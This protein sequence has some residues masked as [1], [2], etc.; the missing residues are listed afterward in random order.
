MS[1][2]K[3]DLFLEQQKGV[4]FP[5]RGVVSPISEKIDWRNTGGVNFI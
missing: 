4:V 3:S 1:S 5:I 2:S